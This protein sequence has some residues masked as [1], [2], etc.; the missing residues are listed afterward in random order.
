M[1]EDFTNIFVFVSDSLRYD[2]DLGSVTASG[3]MIPTLAP[4]LHT[5]TSFTSLFTARSPINH[6][7]RGFLEDLDTAVPTAFDRFSGDS[8]FYDG[9]NSTINKH[10]FRS[11]GREL[12]E[13]DEPFL[14][15]ERGLD[16]H[17]VYGENGHE[18]DTNR[19]KGVWDVVQEAKAGKI[20]MRAE[21]QKGLD[22]LEE[23]FF[24]HIDE[25]EDMGVLDETLVILTSDHGELL[26]D[27]FLGR[28]RF[29]HNY[30]PIRPLVEVPTVFYNYTL[31]VDC[32]RLIDVL[33]TALEI[34]GRDGS[35]GDGVDV[36]Q[37]TPRTGRVVMED[38]KA[39]FNTM[40]RFNGMHWAPTLASKLQIYA[41]T[42]L[43][44]LKRDAY[45][46][47]FKQLEEKIEEQTADTDEQTDETGVEEL[48]I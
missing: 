48:D 7:V 15:V 1:A 26:G 29:E 28:R 23:H 10:I 3:G 2:A 39:N 36:R 34:I 31:D 33:P 45:Q 47:G 30:P 13:M 19:E 8:S 17:L 43:G 32:M 6:G 35:F 38:V 22:A 27:R 41:K 11:D 21:Y 40:W 12:V 9:P 24:R 37:E 20:A 46:T 14:H 5:P 18:R 25:L 42:F 44:D 16:T 4:S